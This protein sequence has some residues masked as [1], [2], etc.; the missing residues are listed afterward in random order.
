LPGSRQIVVVER[1]AASWR[2]GSATE[3]RRDFLDVRDVVA[4]AGILAARRARPTMFVGEGIA[5]AIC[6]ICYAWRV[7]LRRNRSARLRAGEI[8]CC[9]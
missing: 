2:C 5:C 3:V 9:A 6:W 4:Y 8:Q 1:G 7:P